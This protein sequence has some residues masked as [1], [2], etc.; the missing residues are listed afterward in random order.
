MS[1]I[2]IYCRVS[3]QMQNTDRQREELL[4]RAEDMKI[5]IPNERIYIDVISG[6]TKGEVRPQY[7]ELMEAVDRKEVDEIWFSE[8]TR[9][10][11]SSVELLSEIQKIQEK[12]VT[13][14]FQKQDITVSPNKNDLGHNILLSVLAVCASYEIELFAE[15][16]ISGKITKIKNGGGVG[17]DEKAF[18][19]TNDK[20]KKMVKR[21]DEAAVVLSIFEQYA[22]GKST[23]E[24]AESLNAKGIPTSL[25]TRIAESVERRESKG[26][27]AKENTQYENST[28]LWKPSMVSKILSKELYKGHRHVVFHKPNVDKTKKKELEENG[29]EKERE[30]YY[31][32]DFVDE[33][34]RIVSD[35]LFQQVQERLLQAHYNK[36][37]AVKHDNLLK[38]KM[39]CGE[40]GSNFSVG[41]STENTTEYLNGGRSYKCYGRINRSDKPRICTDGA[42][43][44]QWRLD[45]LVLSL[46]L[47]MFADIDL[48]TTAQRQ[49]AD[50]TKRNEELTILINRNNKTLEEEKND[51]TRQLRRLS[52]LPDDDSTAD[53]LISSLHTEFKDKE[54]KLNKEIEKLSKEK[55]AN[56]VTIKNLK[57]I[58]KKS[59]LYERMD[60]IWRNR[61]VVKTMV[62]EL[63]QDIVLYRPHPYWLLVIIRYK[64][65]VEMWGTIKSK[66]YKLSEMF[67]DETVCNHGVEFKTWVINNSEHHFIYDSK[68]KTFTYDGLSNI[69]TEI[70]SGTYT[71]DQLQKALEDTNWIG[72][73]PFYCYENNEYNINP[74]KVKDDSE[75]VDFIKR[76][77][78]IESLSAITNKTPEWKKNFL[79]RRDKKMTD[80]K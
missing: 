43:I 22:D 10:G 57:I 8:M 40:C 27:P 65:N 76:P 61:D 38:S 1:K 51:Y 19:Y 41:K 67:F 13:I 11:R 54:Q 79:L 20:H 30:I 9:L 52:K 31:E 4:S 3:T 42:D 50:L 17:G 12:G 70:E 56:A 25:T 28:H 36:N 33:N 58:T 46:S 15:R 66:K 47:R 39:R 60:D 37:N 55:G 18:G 44:K 16:S 23:L 64:N 7:M 73:Y 71:F 35:E 21:E 63:I 72:S 2:A 14:Y 75:S 62:D 24:I 78:V 5:E 49:I 53:N 77:T 48:K 68:A 29:K 6:F 45:G 26:L 69:Y 59:K 32:F 74:P 80:E 34:L